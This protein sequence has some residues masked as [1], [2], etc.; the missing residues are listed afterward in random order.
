MMM[1]TS[2]SNARPPLLNALATA[3]S[4]RPAAKPAAN[5]PTRIERNGASFSTLMKMMISASPS[6]HDRISWVSWAAY[7]VSV[8]VKGTVAFFSLRFQSIDAVTS[9]LSRGR[10]F[11][12]RLWREGIDRA[13]GNALLRQH[14]LLMRIY[15]FVQ[16]GRRIIV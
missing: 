14:D 12:G 11:A 4:G 15:R 2:P 1:P 16:A 7:G 9:R 5:V 3:S 6:A 8:V 10:F 13:L